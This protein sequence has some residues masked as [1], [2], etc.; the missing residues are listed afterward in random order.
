MTMPQKK[1]HVPQ[2]LFLI[3]VV[4]LAGISGQIAA[5]SPRVAC[6]TI[7]IAFPDWRQLGINR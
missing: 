5:I 6:E 3:L 2:P 1:T 7:D 4:S